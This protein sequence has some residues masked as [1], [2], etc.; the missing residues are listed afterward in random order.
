MVSSRDVR[1][2]P[3]IRAVGV[4]HVYLRVILLPQRVVALRGEGYPPSVGR[5]GPFFFAAFAGE[6][7]RV[8]AVGLH[9]VDVEVGPVGGVGDSSAVGG[10]T[11]PVAVR[12]PPPVLAVGVHNVDRRILPSGV[13]DEGDP[14]VVGGPRR[15]PLVLL[16]RSR[17]AGLVRAIGVHGVEL[18]VAVAPGG[19][20]Y[21]FAVDRPGGEGVEAR[22]VRQPPLVGP[23]RVDRVYVR[24]DVRPAAVG[25]GFEAGHAH[26]G[27]ATLPA[28]QRPF[29]GR[30]EG[31]G[32][33]A[34]AR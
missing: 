7:A 18:P 12:E 34:P 5:E 11:G 22:R 1:Q 31:L 8:G 30:V 16:G 19:E 26:E 23:V 14:L 9:Q 15:H 25:A 4:H 21:T 13:D 29:G 32:G 27:D 10:P 2:A 24:L 20:S 17:E 33:D 3:F 6:T 28:R